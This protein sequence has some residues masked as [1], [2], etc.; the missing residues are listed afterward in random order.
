MKIGIDARFLTHPQHGGFKSYTR[1]IVSALAEVD[2][3]NQY[4]L[5][6]DRPSDRKLPANFSVRPVKGLNA[7]I[8]EQVILPL[9]MRKDRV[10]LAHFPCNTGP[11]VSSLPIIATIHD[12][13]PFR[14][15]KYE[16]RKQRLLNSYWRAVMP[17]CARR[18]RL[19]LTVSGHV[20]SD[21]VQTLSLS[22]EKIRVVHNSV[23]PIFLGDEPGTKPSAIEDGAEFIL[24]FASADGR[25]NH[26]GVLEA[27]KILKPEFAN[28]E[29]ALV[30][31]NSRAK[32]DCDVGI[33]LKNVSNRELV[34]LYRHA[35]VFVFPSF[36][37]GFGLPPLEAMACRT[38]V[39]SSDSGA[40]AEVVGGCA[41]I[42]D[43]YDAQI[44]ANGLR[45][46]LTNA[47]MR[48]R[49]VKAGRSQAESF[50]RARMG[51]KLLAAYAE[52]TSSQITSQATRITR[53]G[54]GG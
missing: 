43:P 8:R 6:T 34:W 41:L 37:E 50:S 1:A 30:C 5:Y 7:I 15:R 24:A 22:R 4:F 23:D 48:R 11:I 2:G 47:A 14:K 49:L 52:A 26:K 45:L 51:E 20:V 27:Y 44:I 13:I 18:A 42:V 31:S 29:I 33:P 32:A 25:K 21:L 19:V 39:V 53:Y 16:S 46:A 12:V 3:Q 40:L 35:L 54:S 28:L 36:D 38:P 9:M 10:D 17:R